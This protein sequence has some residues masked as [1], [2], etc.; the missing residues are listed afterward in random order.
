MTRSKLQKDWKYYLGMVC[1]VLSIILPAFGIFIPFLE[2]PGALTAAI[3][4]VLTIGGPEIMILLAVLLLGKKTL[5]YYKERFFKA[6]FKRRTY[7]PVSKLRYYIGLVI[8]LGSI[9]PLY[10][11]A[12]GP[13]LLPENET[14]RHLIFMGGDLSF[15][16]SFFI[17]GGD[18]WEKFKSLFVWNYNA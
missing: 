14:I 12:Y 5:N 7:K 8:F 15:V 9:I 16:L 2:L 13:Q 3:M 18:F 10:L 11:N 17:L 1:L 6:L 4:G